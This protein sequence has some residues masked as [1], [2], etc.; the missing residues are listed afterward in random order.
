MVVFTELVWHGFCA[1]QKKFWDRAVW[2]FVYLVLVDGSVS[3]HR[4]NLPP[5]LHKGTTFL[6][7]D[8][9]HLRF[10]YVVDR[11]AEQ[12]NYAFGESSHIR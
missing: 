9:K 4:T 2:K 10:G 1:L 12:N 7:V 3:E 11:F 8:D 6:A 5:V